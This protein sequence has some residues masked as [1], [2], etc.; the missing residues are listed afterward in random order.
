MP[1]VTG[2]EV[3]VAEEPFLVQLRH[4]LETRSEDLATL[5]KSSGMNPVRF[6]HVSLMAITKNP[7]LKA[8]SRVSLVTSI[9]EAAEVGLEPTG[10]VGGAWLVP[11]NQKGT[12]VKRAQLIFDYRGV[13][14]LIREGGGGEVETTLVYEGDDFKVYK[15][16]NPRID[17]EPAYKT[18]DP[19]KITFVYAVALDSGKFEV[20]SKEDID[21]IRAR[22]PGANNGP[23]VS[24]YG[25]Q[26]RKTVLKRFSA[27]LPL[28]PKARAALE[29]D[30]EREV[31]AIEAPAAVDRPS[32]RERVKDRLK[33]RRAKTE[34]RNV[35][36]SAS[37]D[38]QT[39][40]TTQ[41]GGE[42]AGDAKG[43]EAD[44][45]GAATAT[46]GVGSDPELGDV[47]VC[48]LPV[49]HKGPDGKPTAHKAENGT[50]FP[51]AAKS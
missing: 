12:T 31:G 2:S 29:L 37:A 21:R 22:A 42:P 16:T 7:D 13:Q 48:A 33:S 34:P 51:N 15:G 19:T 3:V 45:A 11:F 50:T 49:D 38:Q 43:Q 36:P 17:H 10:G 47:D 44:Q 46:C 41:E 27:W 18:I 9:I 6:V 1:T 23:W 8:C 32:G 30:T 14:H 40:T 20:M 39:D 35:T 26:A 24:D 25:A 28:K 5:L 4:D